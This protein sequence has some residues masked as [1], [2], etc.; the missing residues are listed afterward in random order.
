[1]HT[2]SVQKVFE[3]PE[4]RKQGLMYDYNPLEPR[5][6]ALFVFDKPQYA[7]AWMMDT[8]CAL[9][10]I[11]VRDNMSI[12]GIHEGAIPYDKTTIQSPEP[13]KYMVEVLTG[14]CKL[15]NIKSNDVVTFQSADLEGSL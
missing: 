14:Y 10:I 2:L 6:C 5:N 15:Y 9:D 3:T 8:P 7:S 11:F 13:V 4:Q 12:A 1:M